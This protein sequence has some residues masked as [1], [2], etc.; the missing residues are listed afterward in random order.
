MK[1]HEYLIF[2]VDPT[3]TPKTIEISSQ[4]EPA[5]MAVQ[6]IYQF[7]GRKLKIC[8]A[9]FQ[10]SFM[11]D[12][13]PK[14]FTFNPKSG[15]TLLT[16][17]RYQPSADEK[18]MQGEW[19]VVGQIDN[20]KPVAE[21]ILRDMECDINNYFFHY[22]GLGNMPGGAGS[23]ITAPFR[24]DETKDPKKITIYDTELN[25]KSFGTK[26]IKLDGIYRFE[27]DG[28]TIAYRKNAPGHR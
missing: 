28:L 18:K 11:N 8:L 20:G 9:K 13:R 12:Q 27:G 26:K 23:S 5:Q 6:G 3:A 24:L 19:K 4:E 14:S 15:D 22:S 2:R 10:P 16:L 21:G 7:K 1:R 17:E 25:V